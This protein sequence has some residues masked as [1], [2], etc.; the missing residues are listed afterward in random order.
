MTTETPERR[1][2][3]DIEIRVHTEGGQQK[4]SGYAAVFNSRSEDLGGFVE[5]IRPG[6]FTRALAEGQD[7]IGAVDHNPSKILGRNTAGTMRLAQDDRG[8]QDERDV[9]APLAAK[10]AKRNCHGRQRENRHSKARRL[11]SL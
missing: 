11:P 7:V 1:F 9:L 3:S 5:E 6:A 10:A 8:P 4:S 2:T